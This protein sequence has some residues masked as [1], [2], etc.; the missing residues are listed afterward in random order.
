MTAPRRIS[1]EAMRDV[2]AGI[3]T[4]GAGC[5]VVLME[6]SGVILEHRFDGM[7]KERFGSLTFRQFKNTTA[8]IAET[9]AEGAEKAFHHRDHREAQG[10]PHWG[11]SENSLTP[12]RLLKMGRDP[13]T[14]WLLLRRVHFAQDDNATR[15]QACFSVGALFL[16]G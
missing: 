14:A 12:R 5:R 13:S 7:G 10:N 2:E 9:A 6:L 16:L 8:E 3:E 1:I 4:A 15:L 11:A